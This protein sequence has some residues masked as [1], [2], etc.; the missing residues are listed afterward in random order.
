V[1]DALA[2]ATLEAA[3]FFQLPELAEQVV[4]IIVP[5]LSLVRTRMHASCMSAVSIRAST[6]AHSC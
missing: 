3:R 4:D 6:H 2:Q 1:P 5:R